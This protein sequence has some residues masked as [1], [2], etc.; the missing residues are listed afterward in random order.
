[1]GLGGAFGAHDKQE[2][3]NSVIRSLEQGVNFIDTARNY[4]DSERILG[5]ALRAWKGEKPFIASKIQS[6][7]PG[8]L[9]WGQ[10]IDVDIAFPKGWLRKVQNSHLNF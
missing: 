7:G 2:M 4:G 1:M 8:N 9:G 5:I 10:P 3:V 6:K